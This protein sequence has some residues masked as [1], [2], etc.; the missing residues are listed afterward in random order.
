MYMIESVHTQ[1]SPV[2]ARKKHWIPGAGVT[3][4]CEP[5]DIDIRNSAWVRRE[6]NVSQKEPSPLPPGY[7]FKR[8]LGK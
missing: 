6:R 8:L 3:G 2:K 7:I 5:H 4:N 1:A